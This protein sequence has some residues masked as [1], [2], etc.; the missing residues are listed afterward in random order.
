[1]TWRTLGHPWKS[2]LS[3]APLVFP[4]NGVGHTLSAMMSKPDLCSWSSLELSIV[5]P[6][7]RAKTLLHRCRGDVQ[8][9]SASLKR[10][11][12]LIMDGLSVLS[13]YRCR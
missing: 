2:A 4:L 10:Y 3:A 1:M 9:L 8:G 7:R 11:L 13:A 5:G 12:C 6:Q